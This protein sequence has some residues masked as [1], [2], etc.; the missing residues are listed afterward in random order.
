MAKLPIS[1]QLYTLR[2]AVSVDLPGVLKSLKKIGYAGSELAGF[3][4]LK[5]AADVKKAFDDAGLAVS[6]A[7]VGIEQL[8]S[9][10]AGVIAD[11][12]VLGNRNVIIPWLGEERRKDAA[13]WR[14]FA[15]T[16]QTIG[17]QLAAEGM[18]LLYH[19]HDFE[20]RQFD[21]GQYGLDILWQ[22]TDAGAVK[23]EL[24]VFWVKKGGMDPAAYIRKLGKPRVKLIHLKD[25]AA[26]ADAKFAPVGEGILDFASISDAAAEVGVEWGAVEQ[27][28][29]YGADPLKNVEISFRNL[30]KMGIA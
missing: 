2:E 18:T 3:G 4:N 8:E 22:H 27:D 9:N 29:C 24:D 5:S 11:H 23:A 14:A 25:M 21:G 12:V 10:L 30:Q 13:S 15:A 26:G 7:H 28:N 17:K 19:N 1:V 20:F 16:C 6:G